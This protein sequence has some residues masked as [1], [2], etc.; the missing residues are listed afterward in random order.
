[1]VRRFFT[2]ACDDVEPWSL[3]LGNTP[4]Q[5]TEVG[6][7]FSAVFPTFGFILGRILAFSI[8]KQSK[9]DSQKSGWC[10][11]SAASLLPLCSR[12]S[13]E[14]SC[15]R[16]RQQAC[17]TP[18]PNYHTTKCRISLTSLG[19]MGSISAS[20]L[21]SIDKALS[22]RRGYQAR[23]AASRAGDGGRPDSPDATGRVFWQQ[24][25]IAPMSAVKREPAATGE[26]TGAEAPAAKGRRRFSAAMHRTSATVGGLSHPMVTVMV[27]AA[28]SEPVFRKL[29]K[30]H[31]CCQALSAK[32]GRSQK[33]KQEAK[34]LP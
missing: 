12:R 3:V 6:S 18:K 28:I 1:V 33:E 21:E 17:R 27:Q 15:G 16:E 2:I 32:G 10:F 31:V 9:V 22:P 5:I 19:Q 4:A 7:H 34:S 30:C 11:W 24:G 14:R 23:A 13:S 29:V 20:R 26:A 8:K 25:D